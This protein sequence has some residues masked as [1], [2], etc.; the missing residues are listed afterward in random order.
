[1]RCGCVGITRVR[2]LDQLMR[3]GVTL[4]GLTKLT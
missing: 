4:A 3:D 2:G 1:M